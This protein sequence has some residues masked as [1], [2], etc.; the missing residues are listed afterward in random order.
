MATTLEIINGISQALAN[1]HD[2]AIDADGESVKVGL[3]REEGHPINDS[4]VMDGFS[5]RFA[6][7]RMIVSYQGDYKLKEV[8]KN[9]FESEIESM[10][11]EVIKFLKKEYKKLTGSALSLTQE[12]EIDVLVQYISRIR[13]TVVA[14]KTYK[15]GGADAEAVDAESEDRLEDT[16][17]KFL[18]LGKDS[19]KPKN[20]KSKK[21]N[22]KQ[23][24]PFDM[25]SG[26]RNANL[27]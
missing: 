21:D 9:N 25:G 1:S 16:F 6:G 5:A 13:T 4:R 15:I 7:N 19:S 2:G 8:H 18:D 23:F 24:N 14:Q 10:M 11:N 3:R 17:K 27:K 12:G 20:D 26:Q 22:Y